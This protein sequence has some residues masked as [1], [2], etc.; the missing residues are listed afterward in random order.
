M[1]APL[2]AVAAAALATSARSDWVEP[3]ER[4]SRDGVLDTTLTVG[5]SEYQAHGI[6]FKTRSYDGMI[7]GPTLR[8]KPGD[9]LRLTL[10][11]T[12]G[13]DSGAAGAPNT[14]N[15]HP[16]GLHV[17]PS[18]DD[19]FANV[20]AGGSRTYEFHIPADHP[21][22]GHHRAVV[23][24]A[25]GAPS[26]PGDLIQQLGGMAGLIVVEDTSTWPLRLRGMRQHP[27]VLQK[28]L[29]CRNASDPC[30]WNSLGH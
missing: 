15:L 20:S 25:R 22:G 3:D 1:R 6:R 26:L 19:I 28:W 21:Q 10:R 2:R 8:V 7:P 27:V 9:L 23:S 14:T 30:G 16:H 17:A 24:R 29:W 11:N 5:V 12:L 18:E 13:P 4:A